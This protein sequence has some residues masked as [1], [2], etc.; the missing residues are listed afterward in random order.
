MH[1]TGSSREGTAALLEEAVAP[2]GRKDPDTDTVMSELGS[3]F[4]VIA[5]PAGDDAEEEVDLGASGSEF[6][7]LLWQSRGRGHSH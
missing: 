5:Y 6:A 7:P 2:A 1:Q 4:P 3:L